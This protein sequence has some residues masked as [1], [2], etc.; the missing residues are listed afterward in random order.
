MELAR[1]LILLPSEGEQVLIKVGISFV[2]I[3]GAKKN[4]KTELPHWDFDKIHKEARDV[5][6]KKLNKIEI[7]G[8][9]EDQKTIFYTSM[10]HS[11]LF[12]RVFSDVDGSY[13][14]HLMIR[15]TGLQ[16]NGI[17]LIFLF[18]IPIGHSIL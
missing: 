6:N 9:T 11:H 17:M 3:D 15:Y 14:S 16:M 4:L 8:G 7:K 10:Y 13:Y 1:L 18:G 2:S 5:W 12:P